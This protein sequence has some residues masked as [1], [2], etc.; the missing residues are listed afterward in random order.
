[1]SEESRVSVDGIACSSLDEFFERTDRG[2]A[3]GF[4]IVDAPASVGAEPTPHIWLAVPAPG[5]RKVE[6]AR[7]PLQPSPPNSCGA[8][9]EWDGNR[10]KPTLSPSIHCVGVWHGYLRAGRFESC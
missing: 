9:W 7:L 5:D 4:I 1:V 10:E 2:E 3:G 8:S 6:H